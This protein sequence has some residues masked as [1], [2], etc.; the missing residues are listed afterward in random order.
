MEERLDEA[1]K[2]REQARISFNA[3][4]LK[5]KRAKHMRKEAEKYYSAAARKFEKAYARKTDRIKKEAVVPQ[6]RA[7]INARAP[8]R[9]QRNKNLI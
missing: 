1:K 8:L 4:A 2:L 6:R 7:S 5:L 9:K 3:G